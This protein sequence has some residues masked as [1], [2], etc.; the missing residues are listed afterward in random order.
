MQLGFV[1]LGR[2]GSR[3]VA[4][5]V[6]EG[7]EV[8]VWNRTKEKISN[9]KFQISN[10][11]Y[12]DNLKI[13][14]SIKDLVLKL[15]KPRII[16][17]MLPAGRATQE[18][19]DQVEDDIGSGDIVIDGGNAHYA[20]TQKR[21]EHFK[22]KGIKFLGIG[23]SG[24]VIAA[25]DGYPLMVGGDRSAYDHI[26]PI[27][28]SLAK[29]GGGHEYFGEGGAGHFVKMVHNGIEYG[30]MQ[31]IGEGFGVLSKSSYDLDLIKVAKLYQKGTLVSGFMME[32]TIEAL[33]N[34]PKME[35]LEGYIEA[36]GEG[37][38]TVEEATKQN[39]PVDVI[40]TALNF[41]TKSRQDSKVSSS[42]AARMV[43]ALRNVFGGHPVKGKTVNSKW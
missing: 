42:F 19:L 43:A 38:W 9:F 11:Q 28:D 21:F 10:S 36:S 4:K 16:W 3:M 20:D 7:H 40:K 25:R 30:I 26:K 24:G 18:I 6:N 41:R 13:A 31:S 22:S 14:N 27:L 33:E 34:D 15:E 37:D 32:R 1:G 35:K 29:P 23:V 2:M 12:K 17:L 39:L 5:L 8:V